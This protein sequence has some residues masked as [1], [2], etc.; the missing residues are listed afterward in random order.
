MVRCLRNEPLRTC[1]NN[2]HPL[3][4]GSL[5]ARILF[6]PLEE[7]S[8]LFF[9]RQ[10]ASPTPSASTLAATA[11]LLSSLLLLQTHLSLIFL[12]LAPAYTSPLLYHLL[13]QRWSLPNSS[14]P[15]IL[16]AYMGYYL[17]FMALNGI[18]EAFFQSV[19]SEVWLKRGS[20]WMGVCSLAFLATVVGGRK[21]GWGTDETGLIYAN[22]VNMAM[23]IGFSAMFI[24]H[25]FSKHA[26]GEDQ[27]LRDVWRHL[28]VSAWCPKIPTIIAFALAGA[29]VRW[30]ERTREWRT[31][32]GLGEHVAL[33]AV[34]GLGCLAVV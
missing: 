14:A 24:R 6:Q 4:A 22:C 16:R 25:Y 5:I 19:A 1:A 10:L 7:S 17:P 8:R 9:S 23:R 26:Q 28:S 13:G 15:T 20:I 11:S 32:R 2:R 30:S 27:D 34:C 21:I 33:G 18:T 12:L 31:V 3:R 29:A